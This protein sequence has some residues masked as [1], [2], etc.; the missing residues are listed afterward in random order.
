MKVKLLELA[1]SRSSLTEIMAIPLPASTSFLIKRAVDKANAELE[2]AQ[3]EMVKA[4]ERNKDDNE[5]FTEEVNELLEQEVN[6]DIE[7]IHINRLGDALVKT[8]TL[9]ALD[10]LFEG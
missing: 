5:G 8:E 2:P 1:N 10:W 3:E 6:L 4:H 7:K 9:M